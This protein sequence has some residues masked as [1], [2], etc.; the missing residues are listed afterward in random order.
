[1]NPTIAFPTGFDSTVA[2]KK[3]DAGR[4]S[5]MMEEVMA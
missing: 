2:K 3:A 4:R 5:R 1:M